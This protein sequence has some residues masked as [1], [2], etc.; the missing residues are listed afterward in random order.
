MRKFFG[1]RSIHYFIVLIFILV[2]VVSTSFLNKSNLANA[3]STLSITSSVA[4]VAPSFTNG[5][6]DDA[7]WSSETTGVINN[8]VDVYFVDANT[9][10]I[11]GTSG[12][13]MKTTDGGES[14]TA[15][16]SGVSD[17]L[18]GVHFYDSS[19]GWAVGGS[20]KIV[21][22]VNGTDWSEQTSNTSETLADVY[23]ASSTTG[24]AVGMNGTV[25]RTTT[26]GSS[27][28]TQTPGGSANLFAVH[29]YDTSTGWIGGN[30][31]VIKKTINGG[32]GWTSQTTPIGWSIQGI[33]FV[34]SNTGWAV[35][36]YG[37]II[38]TTNGGT[39]WSEQTSGTSS[40]LY[41]IY[42]ADSNTCWAVGASGTILNTT[43]GGTNWVAQT[44]G[45]GSLYGVFFY[46]SDTGW[47]CGGS[48]TLLKGINGSSD[49]TPTNAGDDVTFKAT[50]ID[51]NNDQFYLAICRT[52]SV[53]AGS[54]AAP[55]CSSSP[56]TIAIS[57]ATDSE[58]EATATRSGSSTASDNEQNTWYAF[59]CDGNGTPG[60]CSS[61]DSGSGGSGSPYVINHR[62]A[63]VDS[64]S[65]TD[66]SGGTTEPGEQIRFNYEVSDSNS[67][68]V[69]VVACDSGG[70]SDST[71]TCSTEELCR[72]TISGG[73]SAGYCDETDSSPD[74]YIEVPEPHGNKAYTIHA[75]D[76]HYFVDTGDY[77]SQNVNV[78]DVPPTVGT[79]SISGDSITLDPTATGYTD[80]SFS[81]SITD[82]NG[83]DD[84]TS[85]TA[86]L[87]DSGDVSLS[88]GTCTVDENTCY[89]E[90]GGSQDNACDISSATSNSENFTATCDFKLH[91]N[92]YAD[93]D[94]RAH[95]N[96]ADEQGTVANGSNSDVIDIEQL[97]AINITET[98]I[99]FDNTEP[100]VETSSGV[101]LT[102]QNY[103]NQLFDILLDGDAMCINSH[104]A[105]CA[106]P[107]IETSWQKW[108]HSTDTFNWYDSASGDDTGPWRLVDYA[109]GA[110]TGYASDGCVNRD[111]PIRSTYAST[112]WDETLYFKLFIPDQ[113]DTGTYVGQNRFAF[114]S[115]NSC[116][117][118]AR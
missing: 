48:G 23:F 81:V 40:H 117:G 78:Q 15:Q 37:G 102:I 115:D 31:G 99:A 13:I 54:S 41:G 98:S 45:S 27:W 62:P 28:G 87:F 24:W 68:D 38:K 100:G 113:Q 1:S 74:L 77:E 49:T 118:T 76:E 14:W 20:G 116:S 111:I 25:R 114:T 32:S 65:E 19:T 73:S 91:F 70:F 56:N 10:W 22:T 58:S 93:T 16:T 92:A 12:K 21:K 106:T 57:S 88:N 85:L 110:S 53:T 86:D 112:T 26:G 90:E 60:L 64:F 51:N 67:D 34:D 80:F 36:T 17:I 101:G 97:Q 43:D 3:Y 7:P 44:G 55:T 107:R 9:G 2:V 42:C 103:G 75:F 59:V 52:N 47:I 35:S 61:Y 89:S 39:D 11:V 50:A 108:H 69:T 30:S 109:T 33:Y 94:W 84:V 79:Y 66:T 6:F 5:P 4:N 63:F 82:N 72:S 83:G 71:R 18:Q 95:A 46:D 104:S 105:D 8:F 96:P 29:F